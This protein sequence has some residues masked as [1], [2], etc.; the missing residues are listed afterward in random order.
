MGALKRSRLAP[1]S[2][3]AT[4]PIGPS[5]AVPGLFAQDTAGLPAEKNVTFSPCTSSRTQVFTLWPRTPLKT[6]AMPET[7]PKSSGREHYQNGRERLHFR[8]SAGQKVFR[9]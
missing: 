1:H 7:K 6:N 2:R 3:A 5:K 8:L 9:C 4:P